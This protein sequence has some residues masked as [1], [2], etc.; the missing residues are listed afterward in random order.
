MIF[1]TRNQA[2]WSERRT[3]GDIKEGTKAVCLVF[4][5][6]YQIIW[7]AK[8]IGPAIMSESCNGDMQIEL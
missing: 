6:G 7:V 5:A 8:S 1:I 4:F 2:E 3:S